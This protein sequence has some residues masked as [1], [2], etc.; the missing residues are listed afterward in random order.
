MNAPS[1]S[2]SSAGQVAA[3]P[4]S[5]VPV[6][7]ADA[8]ERDLV[9][10]AAVTL[11][12]RRG[13]HGTSVENLAAAS[14][15]PV[16]VVTELFP[17][18]EQLLE[19]VLERAFHEWYD[20]V[21]VRKHR[22]PLPD[23]RAELESRFERGILASRASADFWHLGLVLQLEPDLQGRGRFGVYREARHRA[24]AA[25]RAYWE[26]TLSPDERSEE[27]LDFVAAAHLA[28][29]DGV[30]VARQSSPGWDVA[31][32]MSFVAS[33]VAGAIQ[34]RGPLTAEPEREA[35]DGVTQAGPAASGGEAEVD[36][37]IPG[38]I[39]HATLLASHE[40]GP[41]PLT[42]EVVARLAGVPVAE[43]AGYAETPQR[44]TQIAM[45]QGY[46]AW[47]DSVPAWEPIPRGGSLALGLTG[48]L[49]ETWRRLD[50]PDFVFGLLLLLRPHEQ[51]EAGADAEPD[52]EGDARSTV[53][54]LRS[55]AE[56][57][58]TAWFRQAIDRDPGITPQERGADR[59]CAR[60]VI[61]AIDGFVLGRHLGSDLEADVFR[62]ALVNVV[63]A[64][65]RS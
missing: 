43:V 58:F 25:L 59:L 42:F 23:L 47:R 45:R 11:A 36:R 20:E 28:L 39:A 60:L 41:D 53:I 40:H 27:T 24:L 1:S 15:L 51:P 22:R 6:A 4:A 62:A 55:Q 64:A 37:K 31:K 3:Q 49:G 33:G 46:E 5:R 13:Y 63:S 26:L 8:T 56:D 35:E 52:E 54:Q 29:L 21:P 14:G 50:V 61:L 48:I 38:V 18:R 12:S 57:E 34:Q 7:D 65:L 10:R 2:V 17:D 32:L 19:E 30:T 16:E 9:L 44:L